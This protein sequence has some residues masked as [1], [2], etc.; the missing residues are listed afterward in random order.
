MACP[1]ICHPLHTHRTLTTVA[2]FFPLPLQGLVIVSHS[3]VKLG[4]RSR[5]LA[6]ELA[7]AAQA[8][9]PAANDNELKLLLW[10]LAKGGWGP[11]HAGFL[12][13]YA[14]VGGAVVAWAGLVL[15]L[16]AM[17]GCGCCCGA[18]PSK[19]RGPPHAGFL[20]AYAQV[21]GVVA[22]CWLL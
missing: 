20:N 3:L 1:S 17:L 21:G 11:P 15:G 6:G 5:S 18:W 13:A 16:V 10:C 2:P 12:D 8:V 9:L 14:Q 4:F 7:G 22:W 19:C